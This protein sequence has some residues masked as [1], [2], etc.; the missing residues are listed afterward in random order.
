MAVSVPYVLRVEH[1]RDL[2]RFERDLR[3]LLQ[4]ESHRCAFLQSASYAA[5]RFRAQH[6]LADPDAPA[7]AAYTLRIPDSTLLLHVSDDGRTLVVQADPVLILY[8]Q[9]AAGPPLRKRGRALCG[10]APVY[11]EEAAAQRQ[12]Q[13]RQRTQR[14]RAATADAAAARAPPEA[15]TG[16]SAPADTAPQP[17][18]MALA[19]ACLARRRRAQAPS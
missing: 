19:E 10:D 15:E 14:L 17:A 3:A 9:A 8:P 6:A 2:L 12:R 4:C 16:S 13:K 7:A 5:L 11:G 18:D 1:P